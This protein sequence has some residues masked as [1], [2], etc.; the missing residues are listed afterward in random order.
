MGGLFTCANLNIFPLGSYH[1][2]IGM[3]WFEAHL[4]ELDCYNKSFECIDDEQNTSVV[5]GILK[6][7]SIMHISSMQLNNLCRKGFELY[8]AHI[9]DNNNK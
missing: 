8:V 5:K 9:L 7:V 3:D 4:V 2:L 6:E 1:I